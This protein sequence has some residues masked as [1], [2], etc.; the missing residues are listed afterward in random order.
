MAGARMGI[1]CAHGEGRAIFPDPAVLDTVLDQRLAPVRY[2]VLTKQ[3]IF[4]QFMQVGCSSTC[5]HF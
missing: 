2:P 5:A 3:V 1:W 4:F